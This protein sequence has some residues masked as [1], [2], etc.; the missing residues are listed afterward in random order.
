MC[1]WANTIYI[2]DTEAIF[3]Q[4]IFLDILWKVK[5]M[6]HQQIGMRVVPNPSRTVGQRERD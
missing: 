2:S 6:H 5:S 1:V 3:R 4:K